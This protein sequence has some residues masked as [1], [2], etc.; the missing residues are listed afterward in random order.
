MPSLTRGPLPA[1]VYWRRRI[2][3]LS[4]AVLLVVGIARLLGSGSDASSEPEARQ[5]AAQT[6]PQSTV[7]SSP[8]SSDPSTAPTPTVTVTAGPGKHG[9]S[10]APVLAE[11]DGPCEPT[12]VV[13]TP[14]VKDAVAGPGE[15]TRIKLQLQTRR[16]EACT[17]HVS[18]RNLSVKITSGHDDIWSSQQCAKLVPDQHVV[19]RREVPTSVTLL[20]NNR[21]SDDGCPRL[22][23]WAMPGW[24]HVE[25]A[26]MGGEPSDSQFELR[27]PSAPV[28][29]RSPKPHQSGKKGAKGEPGSADASG[30]SSTH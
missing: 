19:V 9:S 25:A 30:S 29:T 1:R 10:E 15:G 24:Y 3:L 16:S 13:V 8:Q 4:L 11:P 23:T 27:T 20:W 14:E 12:D 5:A 26:A 21:R 17:W 28:I 2:V 6:T 18:G 7:Q 22:T